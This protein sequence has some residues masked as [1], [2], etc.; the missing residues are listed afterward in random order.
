MESTLCWNRLGRKIFVAEADRKIDFTQEF[1]RQLID[2]F[3][4]LRLDGDS[5]FF[6]RANGEK[7]NVTRPQ[8]RAS[9]VMTWAEQLPREPFR[10][11]A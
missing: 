3:G 1:L 10:E 4:D 9:D 2:A 8:S 11:L 6:H 7:T 5:G